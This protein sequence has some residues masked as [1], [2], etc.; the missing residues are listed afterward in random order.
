MANKGLKSYTKQVEGSVGGSLHYF[1]NANVNDANLIFTLPLISTLGE[2]T[3]SLNLF[4][5]HQN[6]NNTFYYGN[7]FKSNFEKGLCDYESSIELQ[8]SDGSIDKFP[9]NDKMEYECKETSTII[10]KNVK[11][12]NQDEDIISYEVIDKYNNVL[13]YQD[14]TDYPDEIR[15]NNGYKL[16]LGYYGINNN[17]GAKL[18][19]TR[20]NSLVT[21]VVY[22]QTGVSNNQTINISY[23][24]NNRINSIVK[25]ICNREVMSYT[26]DIKDNEVIVK[27]NMS[28]HTVK[29][30]IIGNKVVKVYEKYNSDYRIVYSFEYNNLITTITNSSN[31]I[32]NV[33]FDEQGLPI[34]EVDNNYN[35]V[36]KEYDKETLKVKKQSKVINIPRMKADSLIY[37]DNYN[38][39]FELSDC[40]FI[41]EYKETWG[42][43]QLA[44]C[45][46]TYNAYGKG[47]FIYREL[48][49]YGLAGDN[50]SMAFLVNYYNHYNPEGG[51]IIKVRLRTFQDDKVVDS[52]EEEVELCEECRLF[53]MGLV[54]TKKYRYFELEIVLEEEMSISFGDIII[55]KKSI[56]TLF[57]YDENQNVSDV[58]NGNNTVSNKYNSQ[59]M[60]EESIDETSNINKYYY[61][62]KMNIREIHSSNN[63]KICNTY[64][65]Q[66][67][68]TSQTIKGLESTSTMSYDYDLVGNVI[69]SVDA[70]NNQTLYEYDDDN[71]KRLKK[72]SSAI[73]LT[74]Y[75][76]NLDD[77]IKELKL[78]DIN[79]LRHAKVTYTYENQN[80]KTVTASN[81]SIYSFDYDE[82]YNIKT[83]RLDGVLI[84]EFNYDN[85]LLTY[86]KYGNDD[87]YNKFVYDN[88][89]L[90]KVIF[91]EDGEEIEKYAFNYQIDLLQE[92]IIKATTLTSE[93]VY[94]LNYDVDGNI[95]KI[96]QTTA[97]TLEMS[98]N[99]KYDHLD[100][101]ISEDVK[102]KDYNIL[103]SY[104][105]ISRSNGS[106]NENMYNEFI[107]KEEYLT[108]FFND[109][110]NLKGKDI[111]VEGYNSNDAILQLN[112]DGIIPHVNIN[113]FS[114]L[115][116]N[117]PFSSSRRGSVAFWLNPEN[118]VA[119][120]Y[121]FVVGD[122][123]KSLMAVVNSTN[124]ISIKYKDGSLEANL[125]TTSNSLEIGNWN[126]FAFIWDYNKLYINLNGIEKSVLTSYTFNLTSSP[127]KYFICHNGYSLSDA[128]PI[129][130]KVTGLIVAKETTLTIEFLKRYQMLT[131]EYLISKEIE[132]DD[133][134]TV[135]Y[136]IATEH[137]YSENIK[138]KFDIYPLNNSLDSLKENTPCDYSIRAIDSDKDRTFN[139]NSDSKRY[140]FVADGNMLAYKFFASDAFTISMRVYLEMRNSKQYLFYSYNDINSIG[141]YC[142][143]NGT[144]YYE[145]G[146]SSHSTNLTLDLKNWHFV[147][148]SYSI[149]GSTDYGRTFNIRVVVDDRVYETLH[150]SLPNC[151][152]MVTVIGR[153]INEFAITNNGFTEH[154]TYPLYGQIECLCYRAAFCEISTIKTLNTLLKENTLTYQYNDLG[155]LKKKDLRKN[156]KTILSNSLIYKE[157]AMCKEMPNE[158]TKEIIKY[159]SNSTNRQYYYNNGNVIKIQDP[160]FDNHEYEYDYR[161]FLVKDDGLTIDYDQNGNITK[162][163]DKIF[164]YS[165]TIKDQLI[166]VDND[167]IKY[168]SSNPLTP[169]SY[170]NL[171]FRYQ[172]RRLIEIRVLPEE[173]S[174]TELKY[175]YEYDHQGL[176][177]HKYLNGVITNRYFYNGNKLLTDYKSS[178]DRLDFL[179]DNNDLLYG[180]IKNKTTRYYY[181]RDILN[182]ILGIIDSNGNLVVKYEYNAY[183]NILNISGDITL[184]NRNPFKWKGYYY[185]FE[186]GLFYCNSRYYNP[187][188]GRFISPD[189]IEYLDSENINGLNLYCYC[190]DNPI[191]Y[192][193]PYGHFAISALLIGLAF[194]FA[195]TMLTDLIDDGQVFNGSQDWKDYLGNTIAGGVG[196]LAGA[197]GLNMLGSMAFS[198]AGD[199]VG[200][201]I[202]GDINS[203]ESFG[204]T[205][206]LSIG[207]SILS[208]GISSAVSD[209]FGTSQY[210]AIRG[211]STKNIKVNNYIKG[212]KG[213]FKRAG[214]TALKIG[215]NSMDDFL[216]TLRKTTSNVIVTEIAGNMVSTSLGIWF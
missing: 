18:E 87:N 152:D 33:V 161:G 201:L 165:N 120:N 84:Y 44:G 92:I 29:F 52:K 67:N 156:N 212:L 105:S 206:V 204:Q 46:K 123:T 174:S 37:E 179:Y 54:A 149:G 7:G 138:E 203:W 22:T 144:L 188:W 128:Y 209:A 184:G 154:T 121:V 59:N 133:Y 137:E 114:R 96:E 15:Y 129:T 85:N 116:Y 71:F 75:D 35:I 58:A 175:N 6:R 27:D 143:Q 162:Y 191:N 10:N 119:G 31:E 125:T 70:L 32:L 28:S 53:T 208:S 68:I 145:V 176:R 187:E 5:N 25:K 20:S 50:I 153:H 146:G 101:I 163:G 42:V 131:Y 194:G 19:Y 169:T 200:G 91:V 47:S 183:G 122:S 190:M 79:N 135:S 45:K 186:A 61:D 171:R 55:L 82:Y 2:N 40:F 94:S 207:M 177:T 134:V 80:I 195:G 178:S 83:V 213:E 100:S 72:V 65:D 48:I 126:Y 73:A 216:K 199:T 180:F 62:D 77:T 66:K 97:D 164:L 21:K 88:N 49:E 158:I 130:G 211:V 34:S 205:V 196:G 3:I 157:N 150:T 103:E 26:F 43:L 182:N 127:F 102:V 69:K 168:E 192:A 202:S 51:N 93:I 118:L 193:D 12:V 215:R 76:Y 56:S 173:G 159:G 24:Q 109:D 30:E 113:Y 39:I 136:S 4:Y 166:K 86:V 141:L 99:Y 139:Y 13:K 155:M 104:D 41:D 78:S 60:L 132:D 147:A 63:T 111:V 108:C 17:K 115:A 23:D 170:K 16:N 112:T 11:S 140:A 95:I 117:I 90:S 36:G 142:N 1:I 57:T 210:K 197:F 189:S 64:D 8:N 107:D 214:V 89:R 38:S 198:V 181:I 74:T 81:G 172:G 9:Y 148:L 185:D 106:H 110:L 160:I 151:D 167:E 124:K 14:S 98:I